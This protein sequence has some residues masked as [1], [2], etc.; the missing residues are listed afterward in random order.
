MARLKPDPISVEHLTRFLDDHS[1]FSFE[2]R[3]LN[4]LVGLGFTCEHGGSYEDPVTKKPREFDIRARR[5]FGKR[6]LRL[7]VECKNVRENYPLLVSCVP[8]RDEEAF[9]EIAF[10]VNPDKAS[11]RKPERFSVPAMEP[12]SKAVRIRGDQSFYRSGDPVGKSCDQVGLT[13]RGDIA[14][15]D[16]DVYAKW[17]QALSSA[18]DLT[19]EACRDGEERTGDVC[20]SLVFP[21]LVVPDGRLWV[22]E[23]DAEGNRA[24]EPRQTDRCS[25]F[26]NLSYYH[27]TML[28]GDE[29]TLSHLEFLTVAGLHE[30][31][32]QLC[33][34]DDR[35]ADSFPVEDVL[36]V[37]RLE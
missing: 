10:S 13:E 9:H 34:S 32:G 26:V 5:D 15:S 37:L 12:R 17:S 28:S 2:I 24:C 27:N 3:V 22:V 36:S 20:L 19:Y 6:I 18:H 8:R 21:L 11:L 30:F 14:A 4:E 23:F 25:Y 33:G 35:L 7:A 29:M 16:S 31:V 1:D